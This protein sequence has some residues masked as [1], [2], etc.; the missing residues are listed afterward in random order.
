MNDE[1]DPNIK[2]LSCQIHI[3]GN[4]TF[5]LTSQVPL[6]SLLLLFLFFSFVLSLVSFAKMYFSI[7]LFV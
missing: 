5:F 7:L 3:A 1:R 6:Y 4:E 2:V